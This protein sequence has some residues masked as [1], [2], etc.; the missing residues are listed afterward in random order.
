MGNGGA[1]APHAGAGITG[2]EPSGAGSG[3]GRPARATVSG[4]RRLVT[5]AERGGV[6]IVLVSLIVAF[7]IALPATFPTARNLAGIASTQDVAVLLALGAMVPL[8]GGEYDL[9]VGFVLGFTSMEL[10]VLT[11]NVHMP[12]VEAILLTLATAIGIGVLNAVLTL[13]FHINSFI[14]TLGVGTVLSGLTL[15]ISHSTIVAGTLPTVLA[16]LGDQG[17]GGIV[18]G[19]YGVVLIALVVLYVIERTPPG[20]RLE[21]VGKGR[22]AARLAGV[23][24]GRLVFVAFVS[25][26]FLSGLAGILE[27][28]TQGSADPNVGPDLLLPALAAAFLGATTIR[29]GR[30]N[31][32]GTVLSVLLLAVGFNGLSQLGAPLWVGPV[33][34]GSVLLCAV[35]FARGQKIG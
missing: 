5:L 33:F 35:A 25:S 13:K 24:V 9:S 6:A 32:V 8:A 20:R 23:R 12:A 15:F 16:A 1:G 30:F 26:S 7:S 21:A 28:A 18:Y 14:A 10:A 31:V 22:D 17:P 29:P 4:G 2:A 27:T 34:D 3:P 19:V 11:V